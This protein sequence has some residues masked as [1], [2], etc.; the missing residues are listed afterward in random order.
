MGSW[1]K[2]FLKC[3][4]MKFSPYSGMELDILAYSSKRLSRVCT[5]T[6][7]PTVFLLMNSFCPS[8]SHHSVRCSSN[9]FLSGNLPEWK[10]LPLPSKPYSSCLY[11]SILNYHTFL[12]EMSYVVVEKAILIQIASICVSVLRFYTYLQHLTP[13]SR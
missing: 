7:R 12:S 9:S 8:K 6:P 13:N 4:R 3:F 10:R 1:W 11:S 5:P 2:H